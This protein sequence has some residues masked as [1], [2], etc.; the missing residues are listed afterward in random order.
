M[1]DSPLRDLFIYGNNGLS[2]LSY[3]ITHTRYG[4]NIIMH[5][6]L[7]LHTVSAAHKTINSYNKEKRINYK[8]IT[9]NP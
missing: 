2:T 6:Y 3:I 5:T 7:I 4:R 1:I 9:G 8:K